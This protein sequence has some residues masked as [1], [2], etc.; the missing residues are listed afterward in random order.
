[1][2]ILI[3]ILLLLVLFQAEAYLV[4]FEIQQ[5]QVR[6]EIK[7]RIKAGVPED[8][9]VLLEIP[10]ALEENPGATFQRINGHEFRYQGTMY[11]VIRQER[12]GKVTR[13]YCINDEKETRL[14]A[15]LDNLVHRQMDRDSRRREQR[16]DLQRLLSLIYYHCDTDFRLLR[17]EG[18]FEL[19]H[20]PFALKT[21]ASLPVIPP[22]QS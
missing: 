9:L 6:R 2:R 16:R 10:A 7:Q 1:M 8:E 19:T 13:Y 15:N 21:W 20:H 11:D 22:P 5:Y 12:C 4:I 17:S 18:E 3:A 14:F